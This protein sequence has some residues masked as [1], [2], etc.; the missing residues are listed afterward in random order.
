MKRIYY[1]AIAAVVLAAIVIFSMLNYTTLLVLYTKYVD[2][3]HVNVFFI[4]RHGKLIQNVS[5]SLFAFYPTPNG[6]VIKE[7][8]HGHNLKFLSI[9][10]S[11][12]TRYAKHWLNTYNYTILIPNGTHVIKKHIIYNASVFIPSLIGF[13]SY[14]VINQTNGTIT[15]YSQPF[16]VRVSPYNITHGIGKNVFKVFL[17]PIVKIIKTENSSSTSSSNINPQQTS[18]TTTTITTSKGYLYINTSSNIIIAWKLNTYWVLPNNSSTF[19]PLPLSLAYITD[20][21]GNDY[22][23]GIRLWEAVS[24]N[25]GYPLSFGVT[26]LAGTM[27]YDIIGSSITLSGK[28]SYSTHIT[29]YFGA[30][31]YYNPPY[32]YPNFAE[33]FTEG[34]IAIANFTMYVF[35]LSTRYPKI[36]ITNV[37]GFLVTALEVVGKHGA[38][39]PALYVTNALPQNAL[40]YFDLGP[41]NGLAYVP[42]HKEI[43]TGLWSLGAST[44]LGIV[45]ATFPLS[46]IIGIMAGGIEVPGWVLS[47][48]ISNPYVAVVMFSS[49]SLSAAYVYDIAITLG[50]E[51]D[52]GYHIY[53]ENLS[54][55]YNIGGINYYL[56]LFYFYITPNVSTG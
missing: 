42:P 18:I 20:P 51:S 2:P 52:L 46:P 27:K 3:D 14:Y 47:L 53:Y 38:Y 28:G 45:S 23:G 30:T 41:L 17:N 19:E 56:P 32:S 21:N 6:T 12:L 35:N 10:I 49:F 9:P 48:V 22:S 11:N 37:T 36:S 31:V 26:M 15:I 39:V 55:P 54:I 44:S 40:S 50:S 7:I 1:L 5:V 33:I 13:A 43:G 4:T 34:Q 24:V 29:V 25:E 16:T 8:Y